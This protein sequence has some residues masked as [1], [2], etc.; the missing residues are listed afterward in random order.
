MGCLSP[1]KYV[2][3]TTT[4]LIRGILRTGT[5]KDA[6]VFS[7][8][9]LG[10]ES[11]SSCGRHYLVLVKVSVSSPAST[12]CSPRLI[13]AGVATG[14]RPVKSHSRLINALLK[15]AGSTRLTVCEGLPFE[16]WR[17]MVQLPWKTI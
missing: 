2:C 1:P 13:L 7:P 15:T 10:G 5:D 8:W 4:T 11:L 17:R 14:V 3:V 9:C 6:Q 16:A 12:F